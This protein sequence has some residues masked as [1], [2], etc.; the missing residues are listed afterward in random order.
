MEKEVR[1]DVLDMLKK[2]HQTVTKL[3]QRFKDRPDDRHRDSAVRR[4]CEEL[5][6]HARLEEEL[7]YPAVEEAGDDELRRMIGEARQEH[8]RVKQH[9][10]ALREAPAGDGRDARVA[11]LERDV[12]HH[13]TEEEGEMFPR[14]EEELDASRRTEMG[15]RAQARRRELQGEPGG[16][17]ADVSRRSRRAGRGGAATARGY[18]RTAA[19]SR[20][21]KKRAKARKTARS[22]ARTTGARKRSRGGRR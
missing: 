15:R 9:I 6:V 20:K 12:E 8:E 13:V 2:D 10:R 7:F 17:R 5:D 11:A 14:V 3:F 18:G 1:M 19:S 4:I 22:R 21:R 16:A